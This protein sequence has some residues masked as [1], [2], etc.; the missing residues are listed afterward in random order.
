MTY[1]FDRLGRQKTIIQASTTTTFT[2]NDASQLL[3]ESYSGGTLNG[4]SVTNGYDHYLRRTNLTALNGSTIL[5]RSTFGYDSASRLKTVADGVN[6]AAYS[7]L[8]NSPLVGNVWFTNNTTLRMTTT[9]S[10]D[11]LN[12]LTGISSSSG[13][14][15]VAVFNYANNAA[16]QRT[17][18]T[19]VDSSRWVYQYDSL[20]QVVSGKKYWADGIPVAGQQFEYDFDDIGNRQSTAAGG[21]Q[22]GANLRTAN[23]T[24]NSLNQYSSREVPL[25]EGIEVGLFTAIP[26]RGAFSQANV[27]LMERRPIH[28]GRQVLR[29]VASRRPIYAGV[30]PYNFY[31]DRNSADNVI[32]VK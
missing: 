10:Y 25:N 1:T 28:V 18:I 7:Y 12:R 21:D 22:L 6:K 13:G 32:A 23:Y 29:F 11:Y 17:A 20:G 30:D 4:L 8:A 24:A 9:K 5:A 16:N 19:N 27:L 3:T 14:S 2:Y 31:I 15:D 26:G